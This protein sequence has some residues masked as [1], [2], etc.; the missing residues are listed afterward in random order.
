MVIL[1]NCIQGK[2]RIVI[3]PIA[4][5]LGALSPG[6][7]S[8]TL[9]DR[10][11]TSIGCHA[12]EGI[13][14]VTLDGPNFGGGEGCSSGATNEFRWD[15]A[16]GPNGRR[17]YASLLAAHSQLRLVNVTISGCSSQGWPKLSSYRIK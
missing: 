3:V 13:C 5:T 10:Q 14:Y 11:I 8:E 12:L 16:D 9:N 2:C 1:R 7:A 15:D 17:A 4:L 6:H